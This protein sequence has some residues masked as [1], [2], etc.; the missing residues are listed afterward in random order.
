M[1]KPNEVLNKVKDLFRAIFVSPEV[2]VAL[3]MIVI[4]LIFPYSFE[5]AGSRFKAEQEL[6]KYLALLPGI[7]FA[8]IIKETLSVLF[9]MKDSNRIIAN[10]P[11]FWRLKYRV[12][13]ACGWTFLCCAGGLSA[14]LMNNVWSLSTVGLLYLSSMAISFVSAATIFLAR[15]N[16]RQLL[17]ENSENENP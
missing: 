4:Y 5:F 2:L 7:P 11:D 3:I 13:I 12:Y 9:P 10:W 1:S 14:W 6:W 15:T 17:E 8:W 16:V